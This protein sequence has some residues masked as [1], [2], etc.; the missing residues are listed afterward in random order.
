MSLALISCSS[1]I[2]Q[3]TDDEPQMVE[4][5]DGSV[6]LLNAHSSITYHP[7][8]EDRTIGQEGEVFYVVVEDEVPFVIETEQGDVKVVGTEFNVKAIGAEL[9]VEVERGVVQLKTSKLFKEIRKG[10]RALFKD[11]SKG[12]QMGK[13]E[14]HHRKWS[15]HFDKQ[16]RMFRK[17]LKKGTKKAG[18]DSKK[19]G[20]ELNKE[21]KKLG[22]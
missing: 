8:F 18:K 17:D 22:K 20:K 3:T 19:I 16:L 10:Q 1:S 11:V 2:E 13:A 5:P 12:I 7:D 14:F 9:E 4:L 21:F 6:A 15:K